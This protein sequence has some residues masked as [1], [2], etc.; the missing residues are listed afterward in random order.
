MLWWRICNPSL[1]MSSFKHIHKKQ[2]NAHTHIS[3]RDGANR[4]NLMANQRTFDRKDNKPFWRSAA[5]VHRVTIYW[6]HFET[7]GRVYTPLYINSWSPLPPNPP[8]ALPPRVTSHIQPS[9][10]KTLVSGAGQQRLKRAQLAVQLRSVR[11]WP[12]IFGAPPQQT[13]HTRYV[14]SSRMRCIHT[15]MMLCA[16]Q[17]TM[18]RMTGSSSSE[19]ASS[20]ERQRLK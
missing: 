15:H 13:S 10:K 3:C 16:A 11:F 2:K 12:Y 19:M 8:L 14:S 18:G 17:K 1:S 5:D 9:D 20:M 4:K 7:C 6:S